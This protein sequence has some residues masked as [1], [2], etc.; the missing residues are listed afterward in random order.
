MKEYSLKAVHEQA[1]VY[2]DP[3]TVW[4][5]AEAAIHMARYAVPSDLGITYSL[6]C[7]EVSEWEEV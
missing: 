7:R 4:E 2:G 5:H 1:T 3:T 6:V